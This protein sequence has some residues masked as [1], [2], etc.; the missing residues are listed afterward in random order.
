VEVLK[1]LQSKIAKAAEAEKIDKQAGS[2]DEGPTPV[3]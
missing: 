3:D 1:D 2:S